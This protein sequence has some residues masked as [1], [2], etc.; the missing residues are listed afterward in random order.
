MVRWEMPPGRPGGEAPDPP[1]AR[2]THA[3]PHCTD[4]A[5]EVR[6][7]TSWLVARQNLPVYRARLLAFELAWRRDIG[8]WLDP[9]VLDASPRQPPAARPAPCDAAGP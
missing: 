7:V 3:G 4:W 9:T 6:R 1:D 8:E 5:A 2:L